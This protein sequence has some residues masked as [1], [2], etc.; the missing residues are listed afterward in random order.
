[1]NL[2]PLLLACQPMSG[3]LTLTVSADHSSVLPGQTVTITAHL[4]SRSAL[5]A[6]AW[7][8]VRWSAPPDSALW[9]MEDPTV[10]VGP[11]NASTTWRLTALKPGL[12]QPPDLAC[13]YQ[14]A[15]IPFTAAAQTLRLA[16][17]P[18]VEVREPAEQSSNQLTRILAQGNPPPLP[19]LVRVG[20]TLTRL[21]WVGPPVICLIWAF[22]TWLNWPRDP[23]ARKARWRRWLEKNG[24]PPG[25]HTA[26]G[27][28][29]HLLAKGWKQSKIDQ[30][31]AS[32][33]HPME[34]PPLPHPNRSSLL[35]M[36]LA[37]LLG[38][39]TGA[40]YST[41]S[42]PFVSA[43]DKAELAKADQLWREGDFGGAR[44]IYFWGFMKKQPEAFQRLAWA[45]KFDW[46]YYPLHP[47]LHSLTWLSAWV[48]VGILGRWWLLVAGLVVVPLLFLA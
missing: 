11:N 37:G 48:V 18:P 10:T 1:M 39:L 15:D 6:N 5:N 33:N 43:Q 45:G 40:L 47:F 28:T 9:Q 41:A 38:T 42:V 46:K 44:K 2:L 16:A 7:P 35:A 26:E 27:I 25:R 24:L 30:I 13:A 4:H 36:L 8:P 19:S 22:T 31:L 12:W 3:D 29:N 21:A 14:R 34:A 23:D 32:W 17:L 20:I